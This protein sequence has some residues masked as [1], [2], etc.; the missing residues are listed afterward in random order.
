[1]TWIAVTNPSEE[2]PKDR[3]VLVTVNNGYGAY[4]DIRYWDMTEW[5]ESVDNVTAYM[6]YPAPFEG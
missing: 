2:L 5:D 1:M 6:D 3:E 4:V